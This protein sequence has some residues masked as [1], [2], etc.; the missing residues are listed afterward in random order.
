MARIV[1][2]VLLLVLVVAGI[3]AAARYS[4]RERPIGIVAAEVGRGPVESTVANTRAGTVKAC[5][6]AS[7]S[8]QIGGVV[9]ALPIRR[10]DRVEAGDLL[11]E[12]WSE[13]LQAQQELARNELSAARATAEEACLTSQLAAREA[14]R[15]RRLYEDGVL[16]EQARDRADA[17]ESTTRASCNAAQALIQQAHSRVEVTEAM[18]SRMVL[19]A[20][21]AGVVAELDA[22]LGEVVTPS[23]PGIPTPPALDLIEEGCLYV[24]APIDEVDAP[25]VR[26]GQTARVSLDAFPGDVFAGTVRRVAPYVLDRAK[27]ARTVDV[28]VEIDDPESIPGL[29]PGYSADIEVLLERHDDVLR[30]PTEAVIEERVVMIV[31]DDR[32][33]KREIDAGLANWQFTEIRSGLREGDTIVLSLGREG[34]DPGALVEIEEGRSR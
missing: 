32:L 24:L 18:L 25:R 16:G 33:E 11:M 1:V 19:R 21:F 13:D 31:R 23:P 17:E 2:R 12:L 30:V 27:Q 9:S 34:V 29:L 26:A 14:L 6:R 10:G 28:E 15:V 20:P 7:I 22:E 4:L 8:P 5:R 3:V